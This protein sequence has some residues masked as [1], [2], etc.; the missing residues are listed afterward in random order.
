MSGRTGCHNADTINAGPSQKTFWALHQRLGTWGFGRATMSPVTINL[1]LPGYRI[2]RWE[3]NLMMRV[4]VEA[5][6]APRLCPCCGGGRLRSKGRYERRVRHLA[7]FGRLSELVIACRRYH[8]ADCGRS[9]VQPLPG[10][11]PGRRSTEPWRASIY[12]RHDDGICASVLARRERLGPAT[13]ARIYAQFTERKARERLSLDCPRVLGIDEHTLHRGQRFAT[14]FCDLHRRRVFDLSPGRSEAELASYL[15]TL[16]GRTQ[17]RV[18]CID[19]SNA[20]RAMIRR[21]FPRAAIVADR[22]HAIRVVSHHLLKLARQLC[23]ALGWNRAWLGLLRT[24]SDRL[25]PGQRQRL[26]QLFAEHPVLASIH[27]LMDRLCRLL[28]LKTQTKPACRQ[29]IRSLLELIALLRKDGLEPAVTLAK[30]LSSWTEEIVRMWRFTR[31]NGITEGFHR[32]MK[33]IQRRAYGFRSF[34]N[35]RLRVIAQCG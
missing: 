25:D 6:D 14:T 26:G 20:Y 24:R 1:T 7:C 34:K 33:L 18:V 15:R 12:E 29:H 9:F 2:L 4:Y 27:A 31:N 13:V 30:T 5:L 10:V 19:L 8:C 23:P 21:W 35:Y 16:R 17:V 3:S 28:S 11:R 22:F 32:K